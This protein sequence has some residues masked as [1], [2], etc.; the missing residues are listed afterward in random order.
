MAA[1]V[2]RWY[3]SKTIWLNVAGL[4]IAVAQEFLVLVELLPETYQDAVR[5]WLMFLLALG[6]IVVRTVTK[7]PIK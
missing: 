1:Q 3:K 6:N 7:E 2:K 4:S 5:F